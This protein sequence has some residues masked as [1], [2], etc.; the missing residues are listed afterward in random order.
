MD[1][2]EL[3]SSFNAQDMPEGCIAA[4]VQGLM[5]QGAG[6]DGEQLVPSAAEAA[7]LV[8]VPVMCIS[9]VAKA[10]DGGQDAGGSSRDR[11]L[12]P[13]YYSLSRERLLVQVNVPSGGRSAKWTVAGVALFLSD[14]E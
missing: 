13:L 3:R 12:V 8:S 10:G 2:L 9:W 1:E 7:E 11:A 6:F 14:E 4:K 5:L